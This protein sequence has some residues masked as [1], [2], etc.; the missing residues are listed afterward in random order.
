MHSCILIEKVMQCDG[1]YNSLFAVLVISLFVGGRRNG[2]LTEWTLSI[3]TSQDVLVTLLRERLYPWPHGVHNT[4]PP[5]AQGGYEPTLV[6]YV[7]VAID[8]S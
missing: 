5:K 4:H 1:F 7:S 6:C 3:I 8:R 2:R